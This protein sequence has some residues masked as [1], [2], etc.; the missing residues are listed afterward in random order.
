MSAL[1]ML[2][3]GILLGFRVYEG[4][5]PAMKG[6]ILSSCL[7]KEEWD[8]EV[9]ATIKDDGAYFIK[10]LTG[11]ETQSTNIT[12]E[13]EWDIDGGFSMELRAPDTSSSFI[14]FGHH[15]DEEDNKDETIEPNLHEDD[16]THEHG[17]DA[18]LALV[19]HGDMKD[20][21]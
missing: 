9:V 18:D 12:R 11:D 13:E 19:I 14:V 21:K 7:S 2:S 17:E 10:D 6:I 1:T 16:E 5:V 20:G 15:S 8:V 3:R 4:N